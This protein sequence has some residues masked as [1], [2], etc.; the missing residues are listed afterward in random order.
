MA[1]QQFAQQMV[2]THGVGLQQAQS[3]FG[4]LGISAS[5][6][7]ATVTAMQQANQ[8]TIANLNGMGV[9]RAWDRTFM[10][11][12][13][14]VHQQ[15]LNMLDSTLINAARLPSPRFAGREGLS[16]RTLRAMHRHRCAERPP[17]RRSR[18][19]ARAT[20]RPSSRRSTR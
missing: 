10:Q 3:L 8:Q 1:V 20:T 13:V 4:T 18:V 15:L 7:N 6:T 2:T 17:P 14:S 5:T 9:G 11:A 12:E 19:R 16:A